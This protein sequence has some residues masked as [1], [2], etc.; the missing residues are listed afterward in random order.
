MFWL[1]TDFNNTNSNCGDFQFKKKIRKLKL[2]FSMPGIK[3]NLQG[4]LVR[5]GGRFCK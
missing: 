1:K 5:I 2:F 3:Q 4:L